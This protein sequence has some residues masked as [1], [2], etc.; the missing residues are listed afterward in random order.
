MTVDI[1]GKIVALDEALTAHEVAHAFGG[2]L[3]LAWCTQQARGTI[4]IDVNVFTGVGRARDVCV[5]LPDGVVWNGADIDTLT[6]DG[7]VRLHWGP[8]PV[9]VFMNTSSFHEA[10]ADR[11]RWEAFGG[12]SV[13]FLS[14]TDLAVFKTFFSRSKDWVDIEEMLALGSVDV[15]IVLGVLVRYLGTSD[16]RID[17]FRQLASRGDGSQ[18]AARS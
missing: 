5:S 6:R 12:R 11:I 15:D 1:V 9:D 2:A 17:R 18:R 3:A 8:V 16:E 13:P 14:C 4:D 7:Q 10:V